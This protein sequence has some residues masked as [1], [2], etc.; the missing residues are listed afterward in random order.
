M[1]QKVPVQRLQAL[2]A[3]LFI[4]LL[5]A[6]SST[7]STAQTI[8]TFEAL[9]SGTKSGEGALPYG[10]NTAKDITGYYEDSSAIYHGFVRSSGGTIT[11][12]E[13]TGATDTEAFGINTAGDITGVS[14]GGQGRRRLRARLGRH[15]YSTFRRKRNRGHCHQHL[16]R[17]WRVL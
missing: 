5:C 6:A 16:G 17:N 10:I 2:T 12:F 14:C 11:G 7:A 9:G 13:A 3:T 1:Q 4:G 15:K 8:T